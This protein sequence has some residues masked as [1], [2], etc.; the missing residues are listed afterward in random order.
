MAI[1]LLVEKGLIFGGF[2][3][4]RGPHRGLKQRGRMMG[5]ELLG[6]FSNRL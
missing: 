5:L 2:E 6:Q 3:C 1:R 4:V